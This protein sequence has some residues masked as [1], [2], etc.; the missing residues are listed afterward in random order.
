M[1]HQFTWTQFLIAT[2]L[3]TLIWYI[4]VFV[5][6]YL[7]RP[8]NLSDNNPIGTKALSPQRQEKD[9]N[10][11][12]VQIGTDDNLMGKSK[13]PEGM[14]MVTTEEIRFAGNDTREEQVGLVPDVLEEI[15]EV[16]GLLAKEDGNK[17][18]FL[19]LMKVVKE[20]Y[21]GIGSNPNIRRINEFIAAHASFHLSADELE[22]LWY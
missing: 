14:S 21:P 20:N 18:D 4:G 16:F 9:S 11:L 12:P 15:K 1:L 13:L 6:F 8:G 22:S 17:K 19:D 5:F 10:D 7:K 2:I 3:L